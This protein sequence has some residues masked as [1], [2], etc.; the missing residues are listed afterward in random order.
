MAAALATSC[1]GMLDDG[2]P[3]ETPLRLEISA[4]NLDPGGSITLTLSNPSDVPM[5]VHNQCVNEFRVERKWSG[6]W[7]QVDDVGPV[8]LTWFAYE[9]QPGQSV[10]REF[11]YAT[12][13]NYRESPAG[14]YRFALEFSTD[15]PENPVTVTSESFDVGAAQVLMAETEKILHIT[16]YQIVYPTK[17]KILN[18]SEKAE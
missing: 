15:M 12:L 11:T 2:S 18:T 7:I 1:D 13:A 16:G 5:R 4:S 6:G 9:L 10:E 17:S 8:C 14:T 3:D